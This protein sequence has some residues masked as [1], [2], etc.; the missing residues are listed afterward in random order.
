MEQ[1]HAPLI[2]VCNDDGIFAAG[3]RALARRMSTIGRVVVVAPN[4][5]Q[6]A[7]GHALTVSSP[8]RI[9]QFELEDGLHGYAING[10]PADCVKIAAQHLLDTPPD[11]LVS[12]INHGRNT[13]VSLVYS[14]T[15]SGATEGTMLGIPSIA[16]SLDSHAR[17]ADFSAA[18]EV[19]ARV[20]EHVL[21][22]GLPEG[23][24]LNL[25]VPN[26]PL[27]E[28]AGISVVPQGRSYW[29][30]RYEER[31]DPIGQPYYWLKG[32]Y[33]RDGEGCDD[34]ALDRNCA[35]LTPIRPRLTDHHYLEKLRGDPPMLRDIDPES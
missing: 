35:A 34:D 4:Q 13:A 5:Q 12:G 28:I 9:E 14:G 2:L 18:A 32:E 31:L 30:D 11:I 7:V 22:E 17:D 29:N 6:S 20:V 26:L 10:T 21:E 16:F 27:G 24:L 33:V 25:N 19:T 3:I 8:L 15:V 23:T 1:E